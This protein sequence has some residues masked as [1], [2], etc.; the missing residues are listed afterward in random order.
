DVRA[1][2]QHGDGVRGRREPSVLQGE[3]LHAVRRCAGYADG[4]DQG[5]VARRAVPARWAAPA[6]AASGTVSAQAVDRRGPA[7]QFRKVAGMAPGARGTVIRS[8]QT[9][10][11]LP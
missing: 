5:A 8:R 10:S 4:P 6:L 11:D 1:E 3:H 7:A 2:A 9:W